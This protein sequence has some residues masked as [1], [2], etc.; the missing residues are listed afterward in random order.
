MRKIAG[1]LISV[2]VLTGIVGCG[3][4]PSVS[5][6]AATPINSTTNNTTSSGVPNVNAPSNNTVNTSSTVKSN[7]S[8]HSVPSKSNATASNAVSSNAA[9]MNSV[10]PL[11]KAWESNAEQIKLEIN[12]SL[13]AFDALP[14]DDYGTSAFVSDYNTVAN[15]YQTVRQ[16]SEVLDKE[17]ANIQVSVYSNPTLRQDKVTDDI[18]KRIGSFDQDCDQAVGQIYKELSGENSIIN[19]FKSGATSINT[20]VWT[21]DEW[22]NISADESTQWKQFIVDYEMLLAQ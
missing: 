18:A 15:E 19:Q 16:L 2:G 11:I 21:F 14:S 17:S 12:E 1:W 8:V 10:V 20:P 5:E 6:S 9:N 22:N 7:T 3:V 13:P 4:E